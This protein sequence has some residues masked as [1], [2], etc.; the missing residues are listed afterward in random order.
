[1]ET[2][3]ADEHLKDEDENDLILSPV[4]PIGLEQSPLMIYLRNE[5][6]RVGLPVLDSE[7]RQ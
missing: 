1:M 7:P 6:Y 5:T 2:F 4:S 3:N